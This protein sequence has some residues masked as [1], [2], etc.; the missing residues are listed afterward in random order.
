MKTVL[1]FLVLLALGLNLKAGEIIRTLPPNSILVYTNLVVNQTVTDTN[2]TVGATNLV[3]SLTT[4]TVL[5]PFTLFNT[6]DLTLTATGTNYL[7]VVANRTID[8]VT[9]LPWFTTNFSVTTQATNATSTYQA[10]WQSTGK[11]YGFQFI[12][13]QVATNFASGTTKLTHIAE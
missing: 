3:A 1:T 12:V 2:T 7:G 4:N 6:V 5:V 11:W 8:G 9:Y 13:T 10:E